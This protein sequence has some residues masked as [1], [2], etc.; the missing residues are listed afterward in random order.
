MNF[1]GQA[2]RQLFVYQNDRPH[3]AVYLDESSK[4][5]LG[6]LSM[7]SS[8]TTLTLI[9]RPTQFLD[10]TGANADALSIRQSVSP[11]PP[12]GITSVAFAAP[13]NPIVYYIWTDPQR[14]Y[15][16][17]RWL[18]LQLG[19]VNYD[20]SIEYREDRSSWLPA[21][22]RSKLFKKSKLVGT[23]DTTVTDGG[24]NLP[25]ED[26]SF[27]I[28]FPQGTE[29]NEYKGGTERTYFVPENGQ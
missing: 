25:L 11:P 26:D 29:V 7:Q 13:N 10:L 3:G 19:I 6:Q 23:R 8:V 2:V 1:D 28:E 18:R 17:V 9:Y 5:Q 24:I 21:K 16:P 22:W 14:N 15:L 20:E 12:D 27:K 4:E